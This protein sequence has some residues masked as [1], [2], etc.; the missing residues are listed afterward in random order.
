MI[1][2]RFFDGEPIRVRAGLIPGDTRRLMPLGSPG[3]FGGSSPGGVWPIGVSPGGK[4]RLAAGAA[5]GG[6]TFG[7]SIG[8]LA[9]IANVIPPSLAGEVTVKPVGCKGASGSRSK[10]N[11]AALGVERLP[12]I[13]GRS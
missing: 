7:G 1:C 11:V 8:L 9:E 10:D 2:K 13:P 5:G 3:P 12:P 4:Y 6:S